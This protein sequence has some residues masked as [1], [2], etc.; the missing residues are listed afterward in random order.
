M[1]IPGAS[2]CSLSSVNFYVPRNKNKAEKQ[3]DSPNLESF[4]KRKS[5]FQQSKGEKNLN[6]FRSGRI[7]RHPL[8]EK[9]RTVIYDPRHLPHTILFIHNSIT[10]R[11]IRV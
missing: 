8:K 11:S 10:G 5:G 3:N 2:V 4:T 6:S 7:E 9:P 1:T